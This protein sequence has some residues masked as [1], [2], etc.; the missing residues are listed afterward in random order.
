[1]NATSRIP[2]EP[3]VRERLQAQKRCGQT[4]SHLLKQMIEQYDPEQAKSYI[5][6]QR[7][8]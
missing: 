8:D 1:M 4:Y 6:R 7:C 5:D 3:D 2:V